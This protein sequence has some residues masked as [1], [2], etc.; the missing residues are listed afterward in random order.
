M[1]AHLSNADA[2]WIRCPCCH[3]KF[4]QRSL[5]FHI[6][7]CIRS[8]S[9]SWEI[10]TCPICHDPVKGSEFKQHLTELCVFRHTTSENRAPRRGGEHDAQFETAQHGMELVPCPHCERKF[11]THRLVKHVSVCAKN[12]LTPKRKVFNA[13]SKRTPVRGGPSTQWSQPLRFDHS[14]SSSGGNG[15]RT[16]RLGRNQSLRPT[17]VAQNKRTKISIGNSNGTSLGNPLV[18]SRRSTARPTYHHH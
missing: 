7:A 17:A 9:G 2:E 10:L 14:M 12:A 4:S 3:L 11:A 1:Q 15:A 5:P 16:R 8:K 18:R 6:E 13:S